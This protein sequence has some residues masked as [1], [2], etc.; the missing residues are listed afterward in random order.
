V[1]STSLG[2]TT[3]WVS[4]NTP[5]SKDFLDQ[6]R[7]ICEDSDMGDMSAS[8]IFEGDGYPVR[9]IFEGKDGTK[10]VLTTLS[11]LEKDIPASAFQA[12]S[13]Y[14]T[15][16]VSDSLQQLLQGMQGGQ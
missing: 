8:F 7:K 2:K 10:N 16:D 15:M 6:M 4:S 13:G 3:I 11:I 9:T 5:L 14:K 12:P 1:G